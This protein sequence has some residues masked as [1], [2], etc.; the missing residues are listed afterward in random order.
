MAFWLLKKKTEIPVKPGHNGL[1]AIA[2][3]LIKDFAYKL[4]SW[5]LLVQHNKQHHRKVL[6]NSFY[7]NS[8]LYYF[9]ANAKGKTTLYSI[10]AVPQESTLQ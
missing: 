6:L 8:T 1:K 3:S 4:K 10:I 5:N 9:I 2:T 7:L